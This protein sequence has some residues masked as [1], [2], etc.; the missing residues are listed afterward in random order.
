MVVIVFV[1]PH[2][3]AAECGLETLQVFKS[4]NNSPVATV[5]DVVRLLS[6]KR[7]MRSRVAKIELLTC[8]VAVDIDRMQ[9]SANP[10]DYCPLVSL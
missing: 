10:G 5:E 7:G 9:G 2:S 6:H 1:E 4:V 3:Y 8:T